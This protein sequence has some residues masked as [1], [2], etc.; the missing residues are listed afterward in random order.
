[1][2]GI[3]AA[4]VLG[5][6]VVNAMSCG[7]MGPL[8]T[9]LAREPMAVDRFSAY[10]RGGNLVLEWTNP[11]RY[12]DGRPLK[13]LGA[14][15]I[16]TVEAPAAAGPKAR[17]AGGGEVRG[18]LLRRIDKMAFAGLSKKSGGD[19]PEW[20]SLLPLKPADIHVPLR[21]A[22]RVTDEKGRASRFSIPVTIEPQICPAPPRVSEVR[23]EKDRII[24]SWLAPETNVDGT[25]PAAVG[26]Y[27]V[28]RSED[29]GPFLKL[30][31]S[32]VPGLTF[33]DRG[34]QFGRK[35]DYVV[36]ACTAKTS[37]PVE[38]DDSEPAALVPRNTFPPDPPADI[39][40]VAG[41]GTVSLSWRPGGSGLAGYK[42]WR[43][44]ASDTIFTLLSSRLITDTT[45]TDAS[46]EKGKTY[47]YAVSAC[48]KA[49][50]ESS[51]SESGPLTLKGN[52]P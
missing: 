51:K 42:I 26:G 13:T 2:K 30:S 31:A 32:P 3:A 4:F 11:S 45:F 5:L 27:E 41:S 47:F 12:V 43:R 9:P 49:G 28:Y 18:R 10:Q 20:S 6:I 8:Q 37:P 7:K 16:W 44:E 50:N 38:S 34:F 36:R 23:V 19:G 35:Y 46:A 22:L 29:G 39:S 1:M 52:S 15:E 33:E 24:V 14:I 21:L 25:R 40:A 17:K 48:D